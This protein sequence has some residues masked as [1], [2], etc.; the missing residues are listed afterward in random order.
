M[1]ASARDA[2]A[3]G[4]KFD[5]KNKRGFAE[6]NYECE[7][8]ASWI[9]FIAVR[10]EPR[11]ADYGIKAMRISSAAMFLL[12]VFISGAAAFTQ[13]RFASEDMARQHCPGDA[14]VWQVLP[15]KLFVPKTD[16][17]YGATQRGSYMCEHDAIADGNRQA[18]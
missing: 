16:K 11:G 13:T 15:G 17:R 18:H 8:P 10:I 5:L 12:L 1:L 7:R 2:A 14:I 6:L 9:A 4:A 3:R